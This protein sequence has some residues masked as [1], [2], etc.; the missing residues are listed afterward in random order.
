VPYECCAGTV[1]Q[2]STDEGGAPRRVRQEFAPD[3][4]DAFLDMRV[5]N[6]SITIAGTAGCEVPA[7]ARAIT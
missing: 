2:T 5:N 1:E 7:R 6:A 3:L 4:H